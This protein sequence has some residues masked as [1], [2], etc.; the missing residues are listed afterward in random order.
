MIT[1]SLNVF[2]ILLLHLFSLSFT[3]KNYFLIH[4]DELK[5]TV[6]FS[7]CLSAILLNTKYF[8]TFCSYL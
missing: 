3:D 4:S 2:S 1:D 8:L 7:D 6:N 5:D